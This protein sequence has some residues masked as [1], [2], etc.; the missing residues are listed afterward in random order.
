MTDRRCC[1]RANRWRQCRGEDKAGRIGPHCVDQGAR[2]GNIAAE[3]AKR[4]G[5]RAFDDVDAMH[6]AVAFGDAAA[7]RAVHAHGV[8]FVDIGHRAMARGEIANLRDRRDIAI[9]RIEAFE[10]DQLRPQRIGDGQKLFQMRHV[11]V[12][13]DLLLAM[14]LAHAFDHGIVI[15]R[16]RQDQAVRHQ[17]RQRGNAGFVRNIT[18]REHQRG[19]FAVQVGELTLELDQR[20]VVA[21]NVARAA[22]AGAHPGR[23]LDHGADH[24]RMLTHAEIIVG[25]PDDD[26]FRPIRRMPE[27]VGETSGNALEIGE[28]PIAPFGPQPGQRLGEIA[29]VVY[30]RAVFGIGHRQISCGLCRRPMQVGT[31]AG[32]F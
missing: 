20:M 5:E 30:V 12:A 7:A 29:V 11:V 8:N 28:H 4:L 23:R 19:F 25:A 18:G 1:G 24:F 13:E 2:T 17:A 32:H 6:D 15:P 26:V 14:R 22:G 3:A 10:H 21:G 31:I 16:I 9:H 27:R